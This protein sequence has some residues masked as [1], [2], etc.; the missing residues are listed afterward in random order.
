MDFLK[1]ILPRSFLEKIRPLYHYL[2]ALLG[3]LLYIFPSRK[4]KVVAVTGTKGKTTVTELVNA[5]LED[6]GGFKTAL[7]NTLRFKTGEREERNF[8]KMTMPGR[9]FLQKFLRQAV[10][11]ECQWAVLEMTSEGAK[12]SRHRFIDLDV[13]IFTNLSPEHIESHGS[14]E[15]YVKAKLKI[16]ESLSKSIKKRRLLIINNDDKEAEKF[17]AVENTEK[18]LYSLNDTQELKLEEDKTS[19]RWGG[20]DIKT[21]LIGKFNVYNTLA[22]LTFAKIFGINLEKAKQAIEKMEKIRGRLEKIRAKDFDIYVDYAHTPD[23]LR[24]L[25]EVFPDKRKICVLG[26]TGGG[27]DTWKRPVMGS[28]ADE[29]CSHIILTNEDPYDEDPE[30]IVK[31][32]KAAIK[33]KPCEIIMERDKAIARAIF[34][35]QE[36][37]A[38]LISGKGTDPF[39]MGPKGSKI[40]WDDVEVVRKELKKAKK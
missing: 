3:A 12:Q 37:D 30:K 22:A 11:K 31:E 9:L 25:Y 17:K 40:P 21:R 32:M 13:L 24:Q 27:R 38:V 14:Y 2:L 6:A 26:N 4:I 16:A 15:N 5:I 18:I 33:N 7:V 29:Y 36:N 8:F 20:L 34:L 23:S 39:I 19:F 10:K 28:I 35:A 1:A